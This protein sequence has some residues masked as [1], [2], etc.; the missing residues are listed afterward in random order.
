M[1]KD[2]KRSGLHLYTDA[3]LGGCP[4]TQRSTTGV[5]LC[6]KGDCTMFPLVAI[7]KRQTC[8]SVS[9]PEAELVAGSHGLVRELLPALDMGDKI[10]PAGYNASFHEDIQAMIRAIEMGRNPTMRY[11]H[12]THRISTATL[13]EIITEK[14]SD[15]TINCEY[16][17]SAEMA[18]DIFTKG[19][20]DKH[21]WNHATRSVSIIDV[22]DV[23][24]HK[25][26]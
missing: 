9:T 3:A 25:D 4:D 20:T 10:L 24:R 6:I 26:K 5:F 19:F 21:K 16:T 2:D 1:S 15:A 14:V 12:R 22:D 17:T 13:H 7:S 8:A 11:L 18:A 23:P